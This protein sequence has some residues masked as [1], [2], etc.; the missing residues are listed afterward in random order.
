MSDMLSKT[1][2]DKHIKF[3]KFL[4]YFHLTDCPYKAADMNFDSKITLT[5]IS[6]MVV[7]YNSI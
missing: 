5:D 7:F 1:L 6:Q 3:S 2:S 4:L